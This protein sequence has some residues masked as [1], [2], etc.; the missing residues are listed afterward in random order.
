ML[1]EKTERFTID[2]PQGD[3]I[4]WKINPLTFNF[5]ELPVEYVII[6]KD[7]KQKLLHNSSLQFIEDVKDFSYFKVNKV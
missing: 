6:E 1:D 5:K 3:A 7:K 2:I 4:R